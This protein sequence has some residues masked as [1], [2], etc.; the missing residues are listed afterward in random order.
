MGNRGLRRASR[1]QQRAGGSWHGRRRRSATGRAGRRHQRRRPPSGRCCARIDRRRRLDGAPARHAV[2]ARP[3]RRDQRQRPS[4]A[5]DVMAAGGGNRGA[6]RGL[7]RTR[8]PR[9]RGRAAFASSYTSSSLV[10]ARWCSSSATRGSARHGCSSSCAAW[11]RT[12]RRGSRALPLVRRRAALLAVRGDP[13]ELA[14]YPRTARRRSPY[15]PRRARSWAACSGRAFRTSLPALGRLLSVQLE[16]EL[17]A[18]IRDLPPDALACGA[19]PRLPN[20][21]R[22]ARRARARRAGARGHALGGPLDEGARRGSPRG[23]RPR[24]ASAG[25]HVTAPI[26]LGNGAPPSARSRRV[27]APN[28]RADARPAVRERRQRSY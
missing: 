6:S 27:R 8:G 9:S 19:P 1:R 22:G 4:Q 25:R 13:S 3:D 2:S 5:G 21:D 17:E 16:P 23:D 14:R 12:G 15:G 7:G 20:L 28:R 18:R 10:A 11:P 26:V 24:A